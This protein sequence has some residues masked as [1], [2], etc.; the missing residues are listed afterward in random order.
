LLLVITAGIDMQQHRIPNVLSLGGI[1]LGIALHAWA[2]G[3]H[4]VITG[5]GGTAVGIGIFLPFYLAHGMGAGDVKLMGAVGAFLGPTNA[6]LAT[7][8]S[9]GAGGIIAI[10]ILIFRGGLGQLAKRYWATLKFFLSTMKIDH[11]SPDLGEVAAMKFPYAAAIGI[12][13][14][15]TLW[16][17]DIL[18]DMSKYIF[19]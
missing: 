9:L 7:G 17:L 10:I 5:V 8:L 12:G 1:T 15:A 4:G 3:F 18:Q 6:L 16:W 11:R 2:S 19:S 13:T 14:V